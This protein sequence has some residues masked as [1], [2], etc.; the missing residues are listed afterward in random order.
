M[1]NED[2]VLKVAALKV[3]SEF[4][5]GQYNEARK[6]IAGAMER[7]DR[8]MARSPIDKAKIGAVSMTD[9]KPTVRVSDLD[10]LTSWLTENYP[11]TIKTTYEV[12]GSE[13]QVRRVLFEHAPDML[14]K[15]TRIDPEQ[16]KELKA[17]ALE[18]GQPVG[19][20]GEADM[21][22][23][24]VEVADGVVTCKPDYATAM[25]AVRALMAAELL[26]LDG[27]VRHALTTAEEPA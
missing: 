19:P 16:L 11:A 3:I 12:C 8:L 6:E 26:S 20:S 21:P 15:V 2:L 23:L 17:N 9:P 13:E 14:R 25:P 10:A 5:T 1:S 22:G 27:T 24:V 18:L 7:G 4:T